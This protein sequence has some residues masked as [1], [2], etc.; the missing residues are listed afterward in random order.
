ML[1]YMYA[2]YCTLD[3]NRLIQ[4]AAAAGLSLLISGAAHRVIAP[5]DTAG[6]CVHLGFWLRDQ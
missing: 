1:G 6:W 3:M 2:A 5:R 4:L